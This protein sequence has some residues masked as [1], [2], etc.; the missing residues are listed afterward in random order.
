MGCKSVV[1]RL[2]GLASLCLAL[3]LALA[4]CG[5]STT[6]GNIAGNASDKRQSET[7]EGATSTADVEQ[8]T[9]TTEEEPNMTL[10]MSIGTTPVRV[11]WEDNGSVQALEEL[12]ANGPL[13]IQL[14]MYGGNEQVGSIGQR[15]PSNDSQTTTQAGDIVL[16]TSSQ[17]VVFYG[18]NTWSYTRLG[19]IADKSAQE[20]AD[21]L[22]NG[23]VSITFELVVSRGRGN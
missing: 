12:C 10:Q 3:C 6:S 23:N 17:V 2:M 15:L 9:Q 1:K 18:S 7:T 19:H 20:M 22:G 11:D 5:A 4:G 13:T 14:A 8:T 16:Y 21:L